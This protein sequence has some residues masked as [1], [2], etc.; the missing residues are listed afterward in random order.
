MV[1]M[2]SIKNNNQNTHLEG[3]LCADM[4]PRVLCVLLHLQDCPVC[5]VLCLSPFYRCGN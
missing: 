4:L 3:L 2:K 1:T 5:K